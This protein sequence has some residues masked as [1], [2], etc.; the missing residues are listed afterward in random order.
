MSGQDRT[1]P[2]TAGLAVTASVRSWHFGKFWAEALARQGQVDEAIA[3]AEGYRSVLYDNYDGI[4]S[5][6]ERI[7]LEAGRRA[8]SYHR[9]GLVAAAATTN[10]AVF[11]ETARKYPEQE[12]RQV[13]LDL[14]KARGD[15]GKWF[16]VAKDAGFLDLALECARSSSADPSTLIRAARDFL[17]R[18]PQFAAQVALH[19][20]DHLLAGGGYNPTT[21]E[22]LYTYEHLMTAANNLGNHEWARAKAQELLAR[23]CPPDRND[24]RRA[25]LSQIQREAC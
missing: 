13:F 19:A 8:E 14:V 17:D 11:K 7:L 3:Y 9:Y 20:L 21:I 10:L 12:P 4:T 23:I 16:A 2:G 24:M 1:I 5:F 6:C 18:D 22:S 15:K 25:V